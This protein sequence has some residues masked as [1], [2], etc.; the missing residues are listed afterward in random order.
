MS[1]DGVKHLI[2]RLA[3][4]EDAAR[5]EAER[6]AAEAA[7]AERAELIAQAELRSE[8]ICEACSGIMIGRGDLG[9]PVLARADDDFHGSLSR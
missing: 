3:S 6:E 8:E 1:R 5:L 2:G 7:E 9:D 4:A